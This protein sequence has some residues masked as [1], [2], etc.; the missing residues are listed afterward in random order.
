LTRRA[1][2]CFLL[3]KALSLRYVCIQLYVRAIRVLYKRR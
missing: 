2:F 1:G 3:L